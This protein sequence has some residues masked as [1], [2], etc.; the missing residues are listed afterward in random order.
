PE[1]LWV[2]GLLFTPDSR[3]LIAGIYTHQ[4]GNPNKYRAAVRSWDVATGKPGRAWTDEPAIGT[5]LAVSPDGKTL[6]T[7]SGEVA[8]RLWDR[9]T[10]AERRPPEASPCSLEA[11]CFRPDGKTVLTVGS[12]DLA[13]REWEAATGR[14]LGPPRARVPGYSPKFVAR[15]K[16]LVSLFDKDK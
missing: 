1:D 10:G 9:E 13:L 2:E 12:P 11:V 4:G 6:A 14:L 8:I 3:T 5:A 16:F 15:G 7:L